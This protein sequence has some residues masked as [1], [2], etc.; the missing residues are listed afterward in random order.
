LL[1]F[2]SKYLAFPSPLQKTS[3]LKH[4]KTILLHGCETWSLTLRKEHQL[5]VFEN[6]ALRIIFGPDREEVAGG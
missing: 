1:P 6:R 3:R 5:K 4:K 2:F